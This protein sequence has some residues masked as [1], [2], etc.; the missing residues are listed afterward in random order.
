LDIPEKDDVVEMEAVG[1]A[2]YFGAKMLE[3]KAGHPNSLILDAGD[4]SEGNPIGDLRGNG[5]MVDFY[6]LLDSKLNGGMVDF[7]NLLDSKLKALGDRGI[8]AMVVG[9]HDVR[10][11]EML[12]NLKPEGDGGIAQ[13][14]A[15]SVNVCEEG[16]T[17]PYFTP[18]VTVTVDGTK[19]GILG[20]TN[21][22]SSYLGE[23]T[24]NV[25]DVVKCTWEGGS[26]NISIKDWV[27][28]L[29]TKESCDVVILLSHMGQRRRS[30]SGQRRSGAPRGSGFWALAQLDRDGLATEP[31]RRHHHHRISVLS[32][33]HRRSFTVER[34]RLPGRPKTR[35][36]KRRHNT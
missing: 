29:R 11:L 28:L 4:I 35:H 22:E 13:F 3:L 8:D 21:D 26:G 18:Y 33:V 15:I 31:P 36:Q 5:G 6:N 2:A 14:P 16:T 1:G 27:E 23:D 17:T 10:S 24:E 19:F 12:T 30:H 7:Y 20:Y 34:R 32:A 9:N 25:I